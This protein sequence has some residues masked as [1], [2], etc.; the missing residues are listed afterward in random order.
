MRPVGFGLIAIGVIWLL[1]AFNMD[2]SVEVPSTYFGS[3]RVENIGLI[4]QRQNHLMV[5]GLVTLIGTLLVIFGGQRQPPEAVA[6]AINPAA[7]RPPME[8]DLSSDAYRLWLAEKYDIKRNEL[9]DRYV[10]NQQTYADLE[11]ALKGAHDIDVAHLGVIDEQALEEQRKKDEWDAEWAT[12]QAEL[13][14]KVDKVIYLVIVVL[15]VGAVA[16]LA[17]KA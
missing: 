13:S 8:R 5:A 15:I 10:M 3:S 11:S 7:N 9:F 16:A 14:S 6:I 12:E 2:T 17:L 4:A 1:I